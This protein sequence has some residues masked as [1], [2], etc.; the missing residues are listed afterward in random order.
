MGE[1]SPAMSEDP[2]PVLPVRVGGL[3]TMSPSLSVQI[4]ARADAL[5]IRGPFGDLTIPYRLIVQVER[6]EHC[7]IR[8]RL[9]G[10]TLRLEIPNL[11]DMVVNYLLDLL[12]QGGSSAPIAG[13]RKRRP[14][15]RE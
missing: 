2:K 5:Q 6:D 13:T 7:G 11:P 3:L 1:T 4:S 12:E 15:H 8:M 14:Q 10:A 9:A